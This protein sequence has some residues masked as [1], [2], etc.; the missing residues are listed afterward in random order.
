MSGKTTYVPYPKDAIAHITYEPKDNQRVIVIGDVHGCIDELKELLVNCGYQKD[1][2][3]VILVGDIL[4]GAPFSVEMVRFAISEKFIV[5]KGNH[6]DYVLMMKEVRNRLQSK[7]LK[8]EEDE[9]LEEV[10]WIDE[11]DESELKYLIYLP[12]SVTIPKYNTL[13]VHAGLVPSFS[14]DKQDLFVL[15]S[16][17]N[18]DVINNNGTVT[19]VPLQ[20]PTGGV[21]WA[22]VWKGPEHVIF[23]H[24]AKRKLQQYEFATGIDTGCCYGGEL[25]ALILPERKL[26]HVKARTVYKAVNEK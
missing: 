3:Q 7:G 4:N 26:I 17:R 6:E 20:R 13:V 19:Y 11:L 15:Y 21:P 9:A 22:S 12:F 23:G 16:L 2:D 5:V 14:V 1:E 10:K 18:I 25:T 8:P 24:D